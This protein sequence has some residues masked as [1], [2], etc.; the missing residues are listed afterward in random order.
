MEALLA[1]HGSTLIRAGKRKGERYEALGHDEVIKYAKRCPGDPEL[2]NFCRGFVALMELEGAGKEAEKPMCTSAPEESLAVVPY[3][4]KKVEQSKTGEEKPM[5]TS[6]TWSGYMHGQVEKLTWCKKLCL[7][8]F[9]MSFVF[10]LLTNPILADRAG[11]GLA[12]TLNLGLLRIGQFINA[13]YEGFFNNLFNPF[14]QATPMQVNMGAIQPALAPP[15][16]AVTK[17]A[18]ETFMH[19]LGTAAFGAV[20]TLLLLVC[21]GLT[22]K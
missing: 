20:T 4:P 8:F 18:W 6:V 5:C 2:Q 19:E 14:G 21:N 1:K 22:P 12:D 11:R 7:C 3:V 16:A 10:V 15:Q 17:T 9:G 13:F